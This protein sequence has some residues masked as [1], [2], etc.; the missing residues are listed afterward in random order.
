M[1]LNYNEQ[2]YL[3]GAYLQNDPNIDKDNKLIT[4]LLNSTNFGMYPECINFYNEHRDNEEYYLSKYRFETEI[5]EKR[6]NTLSD[7]I[8]NF[9]CG[10]A[11]KKDNDFLQDAQNLNVLNNEY[12]AIDFQTLINTNY[13]ISYI[14]SGIYN[15]NPILGLD[16]FENG[17]L[18][19]F[20]SMA[21][22][23]KSIVLQNLATTISLANP[24]KTI[25]YISLE[26]TYSDIQ[27]R[28]LQINDFSRLQNPRNNL[29]FLYDPK[30]KVD[31]IR[32]ISKNYDVIIIDYLGRLNDSTEYK[33]TYEALGTITD[34]LH[35]IASENNKLVITA[36]QLSRAAMSAFKNTKQNFE[37]NFLD[38][39]QDAIADSIS[40]IRNADSVITTIK[41]N[42]AQYFNNIASRIFTKYQTSFVYYKI[43]TPNTLQ[44]DSTKKGGGI[45]G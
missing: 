32:Q 8:N 37:D 36:A 14:K 2:Q 11:T 33:T 25:I 39:D 40:I 17:R 5:N 41:R 20:A 18:Y 3:I 9:Y 43:N 6:L 15:L 22:G 12:Q 26:N 4:N 16:G 7:V 34:K 21:K 31:D 29:K 1:A 28:Q 45:I 30:L 27:Q 42:D 24:E 13:N 38:I 23:G 19:V 10:H 44:L 35:Y